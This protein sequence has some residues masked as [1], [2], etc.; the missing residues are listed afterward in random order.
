MYHKLGYYTIMG[1]GL[2]GLFVVK[3]KWIA[4]EYD[5][6]ESLSAMQL[7]YNT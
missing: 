2:F 1:Q 5:F 3:I 7:G 4:L 6:V